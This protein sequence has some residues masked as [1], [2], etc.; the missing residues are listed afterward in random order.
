MNN[1]ENEQLRKKPV[2][3][4]EG[5]WRAENRLKE[6]LFKKSRG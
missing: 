5:S 6:L 1:L 2:E 3:L 4:W